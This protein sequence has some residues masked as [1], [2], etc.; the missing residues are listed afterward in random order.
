MCEVTTE[1]FYTYVE[2]L[3]LVYE[4]FLLCWFHDFVWLIWLHYNLFIYLLFLPVEITEVCI[5][6]RSDLRAADTSQDA[7]LRTHCR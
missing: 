5:D 4:E 1:F 7:A 3:L 6:V 2:V